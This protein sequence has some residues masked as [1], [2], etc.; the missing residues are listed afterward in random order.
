M[1]GGSGA[2]YDTD[3]VDEEDDMMLGLA[4]VGGEI[5][6]GCKEIVDS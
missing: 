5:V 1:I 2:G 4:I 6:V 3:D